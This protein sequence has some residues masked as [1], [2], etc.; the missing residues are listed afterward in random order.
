MKHWIRLLRVKD[1]YKN[2]TVLLG[3]IIALY[4]TGT[5]INMNLFMSIALALFFTCTLSSTNYIL[6]AI[7]DKEHDK[8]HPI[9]RN[10]PLP[11]EAIKVRHALIVMVLLLICSLYLSS[12][13]GNRLV[14]I[15][16]FSLFVASL[17]YNTPPIRLKDKPY[18]DVISESINNPIRFL[19]GWF[20]VSGTAP[21][22]LLLLLVWSL[23]GYLMT[24]KRLNELMESK[25][26]AQ[27]YR[28]VFNYYTERKLGL[29]MAVYIMLSFAFSSFIG[30]KVLF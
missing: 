14:S 29:A 16:L 4:Y 8:K 23:A 12:V 11:K 13:L 27:S 28:K 10:R 22:M 6:N 26:M 7:T 2:V 9:K 21:M 1:W 17:L 25:E 3:F 5:D 20:I 18:M 19:I 24:K 15:S 30:L